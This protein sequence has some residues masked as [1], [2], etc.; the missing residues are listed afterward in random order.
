MKLCRELR[1]CCCGSTVRAPPPQEV[2]PLTSA[3]NGHASRGRLAKVHSSTS[4]WKPALSAISEDGV[5]SEMDRNN[6]RAV[7]SEKKQLAKSRSMPMTR[8][9]RHGN[10]YRKSTSPMALP[11]FSPTPFLF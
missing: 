7:R 8:S 5:V 4:Q 6:E 10:D 9:P 2:V 3:A 1:L 11:A